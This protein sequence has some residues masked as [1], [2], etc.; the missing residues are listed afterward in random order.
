MKTIFAIASMLLASTA[1]HAKPLDPKDVERQLTPETRARLAAY[2]HDAL[3]GDYQAMRN[4]A[5]VWSTDAAKQRP[6]ASV[7]GCAWYALILQKHASRAH[8]GD[9]GNRDL[10]CGRLSREQAIEAGGLATRLSLRTTG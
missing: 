9:V 6:E 8:E 3:K 5:F 2:T 10:Y 4:V 1:L 7:V